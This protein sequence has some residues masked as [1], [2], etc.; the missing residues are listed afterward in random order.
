M[1]TGKKKTSLKKMS[2]KELVSLARKN[3]LKVNTSLLKNDL[4]ALLLTIDNKTAQPQKAVKGKS[5]V[6]AEKKQTAKELKIAA[7]P[8][9]ETPA[10]LVEASK[11]YEGPATPDQG[12][13][14][15]DVPDSYNRNLLVMM[16]RDPHW[17]YLYWELTS[18]HIEANKLK[19]SDSES[20]KLILRMYDVTDVIFNGNNARRQWDIDLVGNPRNW[21]VHLGVSDC[22]Y[23]AEIGLIDKCGRFIALARSNH[24]RTPRDN[25]SDLIDEEWMMVEEDFE[26][27]YRL[28]GGYDYNRSSAE[29]SELLAKRWRFDISSGGISSSGSGAQP[30]DKNY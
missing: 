10:A 17:S 14:A 6:R 23:I 27:M 8:K 25:M 7:P 2:K 1:E 28:S 18:E 3:G 13:E 12:T 15:Y 19:L 16:P 20:A 29:I 30:R 5:R 9:V 4:I 22:D 24:I 21:Y 26:K 11:F